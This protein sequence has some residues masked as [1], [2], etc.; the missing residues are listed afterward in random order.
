M[1]EIPILESEVTKFHTVDSHSIC[2][3]LVLDGVHGEHKKVK[4][5]KNRA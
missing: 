1:H 2:V 5:V 4:N 3:H